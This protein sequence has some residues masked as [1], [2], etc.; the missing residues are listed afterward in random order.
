MRT[1]VSI[2]DVRR[3][4][5]KVSSRPVTVWLGSNDILETA[6]Q[7]DW[8][9]T[10]QHGCSAE[11]SSKIRPT[12]RRECHVILTVSHVSWPERLKK[13]TTNICPLGLFGDICS[14]CRPMSPS[15]HSVSLPFPHVSRLLVFVPAIMATFAC[16]GET[17]RQ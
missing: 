10:P 12:L 6:C 11:P 7:N 16:N 9:V 3:H 5:I 14:V 2:L 17:C 8:S 4:V 15:P 13:F 1:K